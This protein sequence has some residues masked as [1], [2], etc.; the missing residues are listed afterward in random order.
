MNNKIND[1]AEIIETLKEIN[2][3]SPQTINKKYGAKT[4]RELAPNNDQDKLVEV[5][6]EINGIEDRLYGSDSINKKYDPK[7]EQQPAYRKDQA[8]LHELQ[9]EYAILFSLTNYELAPN[10]DRA[11]I[12]GVL[13]EINGCDSLAINKKQQ[14]T[15]N[16]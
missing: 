9:I 3:S 14:L 13:K 11:E 5:L 10:K 15:S 8:R 6:I 2:G 12:I 4:E 16:N 1:R 7:I